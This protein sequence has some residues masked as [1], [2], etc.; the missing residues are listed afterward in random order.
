[1]IQQ[2]TNMII[3]EEKD[4]IKSLCEKFNK[5]AMEKLTMKKKEMIPLIDKE[6]KSYKKQKVCHICRK[7]F[8][9]N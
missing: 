8:F 9:A 4:C 3:A 7:E 2:R 1:M 6:N 5:L